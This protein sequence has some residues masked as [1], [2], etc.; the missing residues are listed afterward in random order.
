VPTEEQVQFHDPVQLTEEQKYK[1]ELNNVKMKLEKTNTSLPEFWTATPTFFIENPDFRKLLKRV[2]GLLAT[3]FRVKAVQYT[4]DASLWVYTIH[5]L[6]IQNTEI[7][8]SL[9]AE[10]V[11]ECGKNEQFLH[12]VM[13][14]LADALDS[15]CVISPDE[16]TEIA[17]NH[18]MDQKKK[19]QHVQAQKKYEALL[20]NPPMATK[21]TMQVT[22]PPLQQKSKNQDVASATLTAIATMFPNAATFECKCPV[23]GYDA[24]VINQVIH[25][26]D[27]HD[28]C[29]REYIADYLETL[30][31]DLQI[32][33]KA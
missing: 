32:K 15:N 29:T 26:N 17:Q 3:D 12:S 23:C 14:D 8:H 9:S 30:D 21:G 4:R 28:E 1:Q 13:R 27:N 5:I 6:T 11:G 19:E 10:L 25:M 7:K 16:F 33:E 20:A 22:H 2:N 24:T 18:L 31:C